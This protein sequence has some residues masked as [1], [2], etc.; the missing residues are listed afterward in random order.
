[1]IFKERRK[2]GEREGEKHQCVVASHVPPTGN[3]ACNPGCALTGNRT[4]DPWVHRPAL[5]PLNHTSQGSFYFLKCCVHATCQIHYIVTNI[6]S[7]ID[8]CTA[9]S[10]SFE[11]LT[12]SKPKMLEHLPCSRIFIKSREEYHKPTYGLTGSK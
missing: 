2:E 10:H 9:R 12:Y 8:F 5:K 4:S 3:P 6:N 11:T 1:M 7:T